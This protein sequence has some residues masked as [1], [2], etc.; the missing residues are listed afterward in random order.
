MALL[1]PIFGGPGAATRMLGGSEQ[2]VAAANQMGAIVLD[3]ATTRMAMG[4]R[5]AIEPVPVR[6]TI[7]LYIGPKPRWFRPSEKLKMSDAH[8]VRTIKKNTWFG[9]GQKK[10]V[11]KGNVDTEAE[12]AQI[13]AGQGTRLDNGDILAPSG[14]IYA[15]HPGSNTI[16]LRS[17]PDTVQLTQAE[18]VVYQA[19]VGAGGLQGNA[20]RAFDGMM[21]AGNR[22]LSPQSA[23]RLNDLF[24]S[25]GG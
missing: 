21:A 6:Q 10:T 15:T 12:I 9:D 5:Q 14:R 3:L 17:G 11:A 25:R 23:A 7:G 1:G 18:F 2:Q 13:N 8:S 19:M 4:G 24:Q 16:F 22:G 20:R